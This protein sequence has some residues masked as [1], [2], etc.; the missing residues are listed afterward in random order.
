MREYWFAVHVHS[1]PVVGGDGCDQSIEMR[2]SVLCMACMVRVPFQQ[3]S[4]IVNGP[5]IDVSGEGGHKETWR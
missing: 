5:V 1:P 3:Y 4:N 2:L